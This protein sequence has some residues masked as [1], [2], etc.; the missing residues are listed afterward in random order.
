MI[1]NLTKTDNSFKWHGF[2]EEGYLDLFTLEVVKISFFLQ[3]S[4]QTG[5]N[6]L[7]LGRQFLFYILLIKMVWIIIIIMRRRNGEMTIR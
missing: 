4:E 3:R 2:T 6:L 5:K 7:C 1:A